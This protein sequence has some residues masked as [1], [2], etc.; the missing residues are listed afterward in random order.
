MCKIKEP[1][2]ANMGNKISGCYEDTTPFSRLFG[3]EEIYIEE[4]NREILEDKGERKR[5]ICDSPA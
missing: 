2:H 1:F 5:K 4:I 3:L